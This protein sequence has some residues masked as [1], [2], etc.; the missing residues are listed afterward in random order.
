MGK[1]EYELTVKSHKKTYAV[2]LDSSAKVIKSDVVK[3]KKEKQ[4]NKERD[5]N[6]EK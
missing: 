3:A 2:V 1:V 6:H 4:E 5:E